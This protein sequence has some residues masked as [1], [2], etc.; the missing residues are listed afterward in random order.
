M[1]RGIKMKDITVSDMIRICDGTLVCGKQ[2]SLCRHFSKD[3]RT[4]QPGD[5]YVGIQGET[6]NGSTFYTQAIEKGASVCLLENVEVDTNVILQHPEVSIVMV[7]DT[8]KALQQLASYKRMQYQIP[9]IAITGSVGK[10]ST[11]DMVASV[12]SQKYKVLKTQGNYNNHI[13]LPLTILELQQEEALVVEM[14]MS[15]LGEISVLT[16]IAKPTICVITNVG[17]S[18]IGKLGSRE[19]ILK[20]KLEILEGMQPGGVLLFPLM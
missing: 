9:V 12:V 14:G 4:L 2:D 8:V 3:T 13:G 18:H 1:D 5:V 6:I 15:A 10:T 11:K 17:T 19:N 7:E 16:Q 20:A